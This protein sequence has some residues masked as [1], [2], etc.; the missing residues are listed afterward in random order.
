MTKAKMKKLNITALIID[1]LEKRVARTQATALRT[2]EIAKGVGIDDPQAWRTLNDLNAEHAVERYP[3]K[4][5]SIRYIKHD[6]TG[7]PFF[8]PDGTEQIFARCVEQL[9]ELAQTAPQ[10]LVILRTTLVDIKSLDL[11]QLDVYNAWVHRLEMH[12]MSGRLSTLSWQT[13]AIRWWLG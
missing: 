5:R 12:G 1:L 11:S 6:R 9:Y 7:K 2:S 4:G 8:P 10:I 3:R 13:M